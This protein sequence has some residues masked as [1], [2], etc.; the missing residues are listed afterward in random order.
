MWNVTP[1]N[2]WSDKVNMRSDTPMIMWSDTS[3]NVENDISV[4][5]W[6]DNR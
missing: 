4:H 3:V 6:N 5:L 2:V 1:V